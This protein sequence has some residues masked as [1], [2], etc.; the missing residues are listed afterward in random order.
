MSL[1]FIYIF[2]LSLLC[3]SIVLAAPLPAG[4]PAQ[5]DE[6]TPGKIFDAQHKHLDPQEDHWKGRDMQRLKHPVVVLTHPD[7]EGYVH[8]SQVSHDHPASFNPTPSTNYGLPADKK[9][10]KESHV[11]LNTKRVHYENLKHVSDKSAL[12]GHTVTGEHLANLQS[13]TGHGPAAPGSPPK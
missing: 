1:R 3:S 8:V 9:G 2:L 7:P 5:K 10:E 4:A 12:H 13:H 11:A 6:V